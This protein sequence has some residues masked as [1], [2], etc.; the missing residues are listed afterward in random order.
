MTNASLP[1]ALLLGLI[2][3]LSSLAT[4][5][6]SPELVRLP[7]G[8]VDSTARPT[9]GFR[10]TLRSKWANGALQKSATG[11]NS[12]F[13]VRAVDTSALRRED[14]VFDRL[15]S[16][17]PRSRESEFALWCWSTKVDDADQQVR[18]GIETVVDEKVFTDLRMVQGRAANNLNDLGIVIGR[19]KLK[20]YD[21]VAVVGFL[22]SSGIIDV[23]TRGNTTVQGIHY[24]SDSGD[25]FSFHCDDY[26]VTSEG[27][28]PSFDLGVH[29]AQDGTI[30]L[31][32]RA[33]V[34]T[35]P[36]KEVG[37]RA[38]AE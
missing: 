18:A 7:R 20:K 15:T 22:V 6:A 1:P 23:C 13:A 3:S 25:W 27:M 35:L 4:P 14:R 11:E 12:H 38:A 30:R 9:G 29:V 19:V 8:P 31:H 10:W 33:D 17:E 24:R 2:C 37:V 36:A 16:P 21:P 32:H 28:H 26:F 5:P 34:G